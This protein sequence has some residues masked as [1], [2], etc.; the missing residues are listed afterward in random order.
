M[1]IL[2][3]HYRL[4]DSDGNVISHDIPG[5]TGSVNKLY[6]LTLPDIIQ[7][8]VATTDMVSTI[9]AN[10]GDPT[11]TTSVNAVLLGS[12]G[13]CWKVNAEIWS[14]VGRVANRIFYRITWRQ[15][16]TGS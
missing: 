5:V 10:K 6:N 2:T 8:G 9:R 14:D 11:V 15:Q 4:Q 16:G 12:F 1:P 13:N 7:E 3:A